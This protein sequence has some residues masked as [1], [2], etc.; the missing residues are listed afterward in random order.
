[1]A[2]EECPVCRAGQQFGSWKPITSNAQQR[3]QKMT[4]HSL[5][6]HLKS[7]RLSCWFAFSCNIES[8]GYSTFFCTVKSTD[9]MNI[10]VALRSRGPDVRH[11]AW[12]SSTILKL[13][14]RFFVFLGP[15]RLLPHAWSRYIAILCSC[16]WCGGSTIYSPSWWD[17][18]GECCK[19]D[20][21]F[22]GIVQRFSLTDECML[23][24]LVTPA[25]WY[26]YEVD[27]CSS[28][29]WFIGHSLPSTNRV[30]ILSRRINPHDPITAI[31]SFFS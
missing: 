15:R 20:V 11:T 4:S 29:P 7:V 25:I 3:A 18:A 21:I 13:C 2:F 8:D 14:P 10:Q 26:F 31:T 12:S 17:R 5:I 22:K 30:F 16:S 1:M 6:S 23:I 28:A 19:I 27:T 9:V 24:C